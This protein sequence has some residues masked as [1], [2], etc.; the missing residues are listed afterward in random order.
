VLEQ[1]A[2][3]LAYVHAHGMVHRDLKSA[4]VLIADGFWGAPH[5]AGGVKL[6]D[7]GIAAPIGNPRPVTVVG[8]EIGTAAYM[9]PE[10][11]SGR[12]RAEHAEGFARDMFA[13]GVLACEILGGAHPTG[14]SWTAP[15]RAF[16]DAYRG[17]AA[18]PR[19]WPPVDLGGPFGG[20]VR[21][22]LALD[23][24]SR[25]EGGAALAQS[26]RFGSAK[27]AAPSPGPARGP[28]TTPHPHATEPPRS[29]AW[30]GGDTPAPS[31]VPA[32][33]RAST[34]GV[35][36][37]PARSFWL[38]KALGVLLFGGAAA[39]GGAVLYDRWIARPPA[40]PAPMVVAPVVV[41]PVQP[42]PVE[43]PAIEA[44]LDAP[45]PEALASCQSGR[46]C[47]PGLPKTRIPERTWWLRVSGVAGRTPAGFGED[48]GG[49][50]PLATL[51]LRRLGSSDPEVFVPFSAMVKAGG[52]RVH[53]LRVTTSDLTGGN[54]GIRINEAGADIMSGTSAPTQGALLTTALCGG[55]PLYIG[56]R[57][58]ALAKVNLFLDER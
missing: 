36:P 5:L 53:R 35:A 11:L 37:P 43:P 56:D 50:H 20:V 28:M 21:A 39:I 54:I 17:L 6:V 30:P 4:N 34:S 29:A 32:R 38:A 31:Y 2:D 46:K 13:Y 52:D 23:P 48:M 57:A 3:T 55:T 44:P 8:Q 15:A 7:F 22:C 58:S 10:L 51:G 41:A 19:S 47:T 42:S 49:T 40:I 16:A 1:L 14:L 27:V 25:P 18:E 33:T 45:C 26:L 24:R 12:P 9:A